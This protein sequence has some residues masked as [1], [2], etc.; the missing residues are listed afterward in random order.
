MMVTSA[1]RHGSGRSQHE[2]GEAIDIQVPGLSKQGYFEM[3]QWI[4][5]NLPYDQLLYEEKNTGTKLPWIHVS[6][7]RGKQRYQVMSFFNHRKVAD[8]LVR[9]S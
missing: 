1:F 9:M 2:R 3:A 4:K 6:L 8:G 5:V 7:T